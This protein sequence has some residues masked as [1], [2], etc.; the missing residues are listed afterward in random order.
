M[1]NTEHKILD[2]AVKVFSSEGYAGAT[3]RKIAQEANV[4]E[5]TLFRKFQSKENLL[6]EVLIKNRYSISTLNKLLNVNKNADIERDLCILGK[7]ITKDM[8][9]EKKNSISYMFM[10]ML[11]EEG[12][13]RPELA[14]ILESVFKTNIERLSEY[15]ELQM[16][17][18]KIRNINAQSAALTFVS[19]FSCSAFLR[20]IF[21]DYALSYNDKDVEN[22]IDIFTKGILKVEKTENVLEKEKKLQKLKEDI[23]RKHE[24]LN[25]LEEQVRELEKE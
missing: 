24:A 21:V 6:K 8:Q 2:A 12:R 16:K 7:E 25:S 20:G 11:F 1:R 13:R 3:T 18:G 5:V 17:N 19:Y 9:D 4:T 22:F 23:S 15:F 10:F 14:E